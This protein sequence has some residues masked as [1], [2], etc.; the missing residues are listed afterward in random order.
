MRHW[1]SLILGLLACFLHG[2]DTLSTVVIYSSIPDSYKADVML[3]INGQSIYP[4]PLGYQ[5]KLTHELFS[6]GNMTLVAKVT[7]KPGYK[8]AV[9][10][11][12]IQPGSTTVLWLTVLVGVNDTGTVFVNNITESDKQITKLEKKEA[13]GKWSTI[14]SKE[15][16]DS[17]YNSK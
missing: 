11:L 3:E 4:A 16:S 1:F 5:V 13:G 9:V 15:N 8:S 6:S 14:R 12:Q 10:E 7:N 17:P 2:Q